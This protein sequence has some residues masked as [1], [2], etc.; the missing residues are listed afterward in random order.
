MAMEYVEG[1]DLARLPGITNE[2]SWA[3]ASEMGSALAYIHQLGIIHQDLKPANILV[4]LN[5]HSSP[6]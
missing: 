3:M 1:R 5:S 2:E 6:N 4:F